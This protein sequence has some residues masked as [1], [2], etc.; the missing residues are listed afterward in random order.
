MKKLMLVLIVLAVACKKKEVK[1][2]EP[3][4]PSPTY[5]YKLTVSAKTAAFSQTATPIGASDP[6]DSTYY[7]L[8]AGSK[9]VTFKSAVNA[10]SLNNVLIID[11]VKTGDKITFT[12]RMITYTPNP[13]DC[14]FTVNKVWLNKKTDNSE[15][16]LSGSV[17]YTVPMTNKAANKTVEYTAP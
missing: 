8:R 13:G 10:G 2:E 4:Q 15:T 9:T 6:K 14:K 5:Y 16:V 12:V 7:E 1:P 17:T 3:I 11:S